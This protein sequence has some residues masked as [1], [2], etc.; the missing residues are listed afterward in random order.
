MTDLSVYM[1]LRRMVSDQ[2]GRFAFADLGPGVY[3][4]QAVAMDSCPATRSI[5]LGA[6]EHRSQFDW[7]LDA[8]H[9]LDGRVLGPDGAARARISVRLQSLE[10]PPL[11]TLQTVTDSAGHFDF[12]EVCAGRYSLSCRPPS[13]NERLAPAFVPEVIF[14][15][16]PLELR[17]AELDA[18]LRG[19]V[20]DH[21]GAPVHLALVAIDYGSGGRTGGVLTDTAGRFALQLPAGRS[22]TV[23][24]WQTGPLDLSEGTP[25]VRELGLKR[26]ILDSG[27]PAASAEGVTSGGGDLEIQ[28]PSE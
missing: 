3:E 6:G 17:L 24:A 19:R 28:L 21:A 10:T 18:E 11:P 4:L 27:H 12:D 14:D 25:S 23:R 15:G 7:T 1:H 20:T 9:S 22:I 8:T 26:R 5:E 13:S 2:R 16:R